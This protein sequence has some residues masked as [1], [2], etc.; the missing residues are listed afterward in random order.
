MNPKVLLAILPLLMPAVAAESKPNILFLFADDMTWK[1][2]RA[3]GKEDIDTPNLDR[4][5]ARGTAFTQAYNPGGWHGAICVAS[6]TMLMTGKQ[7]WRARDAEKRLNQDFVAK[8]LM[9]PQRMAAQGYRTCFAGKW[10]IEADHKKVFSQIRTYHPGGMPKDAQHAYFRPVEGQPDPWDAADPKEGGFWAGGKHWSERMVDDFNAFAAD[11]DPQPWFMY[12]AFNA[13]HDPRQAPQEF[14]DRYPLSRVKVPGNFLPLYPHRKA[15]GAAKGLRDEN[16]APF[17]R[18]T[19][20]VQTH[21]R[22][23]YAIVSH[24]DVQIGKILDAL[25]KHEDGANTYIFFT[26]DHGL[27]CGDHGLMGKQNLY[28]ASVRVP[29]LVAGPGVPAGKKIDAPVYLQDAMPTALKLAGAE[30]GDD[31]DFQDMRPHWEGKGKRRDAAI[32]AYMDLQ[33][34]IEKDGKKLILYPKAKVA[35][36]FDLQ[37]D[38][39]EMN[40]LAETPA[41]KALAIPLF[42]RLREI[43]RESGDPLDLA[44]LFPDLAAKGKGEKTR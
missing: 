44:D 31:I 41:G 9:W 27:A 6:R 36:V 43:Q 42:Q 37:A 22:E 26:A 12:L 18:T 21:R 29:F 20:A 7:L 14:L 34:M 33:R 4:L 40:D 1:S 35:R 16:L 3:L 2:V 24:L 25:E 8:D 13:P 30:V 17:P 38:P 11:A 10:H 39:E 15:M 28:D 5:A 23:Y 32:G 19:F